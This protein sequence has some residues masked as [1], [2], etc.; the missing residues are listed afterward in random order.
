MLLDTFLI[1]E[2]GYPLCKTCSELNSEIECLE[3]D[4]N[5]ACIATT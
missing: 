1:I 3:C 2:S 4:E 5:G